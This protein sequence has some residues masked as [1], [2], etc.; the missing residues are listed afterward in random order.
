[1]INWKKKKEEVNP[2]IEKNY[3]QYLK[4]IAIKITVNRKLKNLTQI[5]IANDLQLS[6][7]TISN[8]E[9]DIKNLS[10]IN[11]IKILDYLDME[12]VLQEKVKTENE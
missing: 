1:M 8:C 4:N 3:E 11:L 6:P 12:L 10:F 5:K 2:L 7:A 9:R